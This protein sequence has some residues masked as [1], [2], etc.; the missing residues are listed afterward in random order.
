MVTVGKRKKKKKRV[1]RS[2]DQDLFDVAEQPKMVDH[3]KRSDR[4]ISPCCGEEEEEQTVTQDM[5]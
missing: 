5:L 4:R 1:A 3:G 2:Q